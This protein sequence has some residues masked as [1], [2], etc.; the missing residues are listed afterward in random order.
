M[1]RTMTCNNASSAPFS[2]RNGFLPNA[3]YSAP[4]PASHYALRETNRAEGG[5]NQNPSLRGY[6]SQSVM[7]ASP[8]ASAATTPLASA[9]GGFS[10]GLV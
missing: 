6:A 9:G 3:T 8:S 2:A 5:N 4:R 1:S 7:T 10:E